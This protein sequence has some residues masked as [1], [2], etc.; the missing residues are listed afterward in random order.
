MIYL[1]FYHGR[2]IFKG[3][4]FS[5]WIKNNFKTVKFEGF[6]YGHYMPTISVSLQE[7]EAAKDFIPTKNLI[8]VEGRFSILEQ[9]VF[10]VRDFKNEVYEKVDEAAL[11]FSA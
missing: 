10:G 6:E 2:N 11:E 4:E 9:L 5:S 1:T 7:F 3:H 8:R